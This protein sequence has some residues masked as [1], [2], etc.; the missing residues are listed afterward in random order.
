M[1]NLQKVA[2]FMRGGVFY[3]ATVDENSK[4]KVRPFGAVGVING[5]LYICTNS[6]KEVSK[7]FKRAGECEIAMTNAEGLWLRLTA[8]VKLDE[9]EPS[10][11]MMFEQNPN[12]NAIYEGKKDIFEV[13]YLKMQRRAL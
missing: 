2:D 13:F 4:P 12:L 10:K 3:V 1:T 6:T 11:E 5:R 8:N 7:Q 9:N